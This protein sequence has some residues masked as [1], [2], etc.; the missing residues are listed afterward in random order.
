MCLVESVSWEVSQSS[1]MNSNFECPKSSGTLSR[2]H[3]AVLSFNILTYSEP[4][5]NV[6][7]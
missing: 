6:Q 4:R 5:L 3:I 7:L 1:Y 2:S